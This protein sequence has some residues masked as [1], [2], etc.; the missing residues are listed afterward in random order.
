[1]TFGVLNYLTSKAIN[2]IDLSPYLVSGKRIL[3]NIIIKKYICMCIC[4]CVY[5]PSE[6]YTIVYIC[7]NLRMFTHILQKLTSISMKKK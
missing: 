2:H 3:L 5:A 6:I 7:K 4:I 1:M